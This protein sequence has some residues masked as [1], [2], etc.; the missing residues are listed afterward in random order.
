[1]IDYVILTGAI[2]LAITALDPLSF[3]VPKAK[4]RC[5]YCR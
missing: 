3:M 2:V 5:F 4:C 1:M